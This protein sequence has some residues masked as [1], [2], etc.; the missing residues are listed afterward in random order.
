M[1]DQRRL[2]N[3]GSAAEDGDWLQLA[4][5]P[6]RTACALKG[7]APPYRARWIWCGPDKTLRNRAA[8]PAWPDDLAVGTQPGVN[9]PMP[10]RVPF[11]FAGRAQP[12]AAGGR[13]FIGDMDGTIYAIA[14]QDGRMLWANPNPG[15]TCAALAV[16]HDVV[17]ATAIP[18]GMSG[19]D[20][21]TGQPRWHLDTPK[22]ITGA[23]LVVGNKAVTGCHDGRV[24]AVEVSTGKPLWTSPYL[25]APVVSDLCGD[26][27]A[28]YVGAENMFFHKLDP[29]TGQVLVKTR[30]N[31]QSFRML[32]PVLHHGL[33]FVQTVQPICVGSE[34][35]MEGVM[36]DSPDIRSEQTNILRWLS[37]DTNGGQWPDA[38]PAWKHLFVLR[39]ADLSEPFT[40]PNGAADGCGSPAPPPVVDGA[41]RV[42]AWFK[43]AHPT[44]TAK[45]AFGTRYSMDISAIDLVTG[46]R[47]PI[48]NGRSQRHDRGE[49]QPLCAERRRTFSLPAP[50]LSRDKGHRPGAQHRSCDP[51]RVAFPGR[52]QLA[53]RR[54]LSRH[55]R[56][57]LPLP[58][59]A[60]RARGCG[61]R[62]GQAAVCR[63]ILRNLRRA[64][65]AMKTMN[66]LLRPAMLL[67]C[68]LVLAGIG[69]KPVPGWA[70]EGGWDRYLWETCR[71]SAVPASASNLVT[72]LR[73]E[74][75]KVLASGPL[76]P[77]RTVYADLEEDPYFMYW[78]GGRI[79]TTLAMAWPHL[80]ESQRIQ[81][82]SYIRAEL[83]D[84]QR[85]PWAPKGFIPPDRG[86]RRELH[87]F[88]EPRGW[89]RYWS[90]WGKR[91][92]TMG[93]FYGLWLYVEPL[94]GLGC[95]SNVLSQ[96]R[97]TLLAEGERGRALRDDGRAYR[98]GANRPAF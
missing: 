45:G 17:V 6:G 65:R 26:E 33:L 63:G 55:A 34:Y 56:P 96:A 64:P 16:V 94:L 80:T 66:Q 62:R 97:R 79:V 13:V 4:H 47:V 7:V 84:E 59:G 27:T 28:L 35:V 53:G 95:P 82:R 73:A 98:H 5:D 36:R 29:A 60:G 75:D 70:A 37:G 85:A 61:H 2:T 40:V 21:A 78:Q 32:F 31:G 46:L 77:M 9:Y 39:A 10:E 67:L 81:I 14:L 42:L 25:G 22:A 89:D 71:C 20:A 74:V 54:G 83:E 49:R 1:A 93:S 57:A 24:Y 92:P 72:E 86:S 48:D 68:G 52:R 23:P 41:G 30:L 11:T 90:M 69:F 51:G 50:A 44:L 18:G 43:T 19:F 91:K 3:P 8:D 15:G 58:T 88:H 38:S 76:A 12:V 87:T